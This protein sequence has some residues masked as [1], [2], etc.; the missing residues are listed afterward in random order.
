M[1]IYDVAAESGGAVTI[2]NKY[3]E[4][5]LDNEDVESYFILSI[6][7]YP[8]SKFLHTI[9]LPWVKKT[10]FHRLYCDN[11]YIYKLIK[12]LKIDEV[13]SLQNIAVKK[14]PVPQTVYVQNAIPFTEYRFSLRK[15]PY[16]WVYQNIIGRI[17]R[18]SLTSANTIIVQT[19]WMKK[20]ICSSCKVPSNIIHVESVSNGI[21]VEG[22]RQSCNRSV[23]FYPATALSYKNHI[24]ILNA[25][26]LLEKESL[27]NYEIVFTISENDNKLA[28]TIVDK[29]KNNKLP[30]R[31][32]GRLST[33]KM[34]DYYQKSCL[35]F[36]SYLETVGLPLIEAKGFGCDIFVANCEYSKEVIGDYERAKFFEKEDYIQLASFMKNYIL[37]NA[38][39]GIREQ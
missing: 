19:N 21:K 22:K 39:E 27:P 33:E 36:P 8:E 3:Y 17:T 9:N 26:S 13:Y 31:C 10:W 2:L 25:C 29:I 30:I 18:H 34:I 14:C 32:V 28:K 16:L 38:L 6:L 4:E 7:S 37:Q 24:T 11:W 35:L 5:F 12:K 1:L 15:T 20:A 23:F